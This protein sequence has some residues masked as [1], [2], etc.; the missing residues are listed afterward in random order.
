MNS[1]KYIYK[2]QDVNGV[3]PD[4]NGQIFYIERVKKVIYLF[5]YTVENFF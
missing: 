1:E 5:H 2:P 3:L 4:A